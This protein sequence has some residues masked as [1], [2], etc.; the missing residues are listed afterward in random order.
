VS[1]VPNGGRDG[2]I[3]ALIESWRAGS[4]Q[5]NKDD[6]E[7]SKSAAEEHGGAKVESGKDRRM[8]VEQMTALIESLLIPRFQSLLEAVEAVNTGTVERQE[9]QGGQEGVG[10]VLTEAETLAER[11]LE[12]GMT[13]G[14]R[15]LV[16]TLV[17]SGVSVEEAVSQVGEAAKEATKAA[18]ESAA[19]LE[20]SGAPKREAV[21]VNWG[22]K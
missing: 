7:E 16:Y 3:E 13:T 14:Q 18:A 17:N 21:K 8:D 15:K 5:Q 11:L 1:I 20:Y 6:K 10:D 2:K 4:G 9:G 22:R 19:F 12:A